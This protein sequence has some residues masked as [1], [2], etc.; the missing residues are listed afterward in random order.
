M[1]IVH[2]AH[3][4]EY[5]WVGQGRKRQYQPVPCGGCTLVVIKDDNGMLKVGMAA[6]RKDEHYVRRQGIDVAAE[7][8]K[9]SSS[10]ISYPKV[11]KREAESLVNAIP[12]HL[13]LEM[14][15]QSEAN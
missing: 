9:A 4:R 13:I 15:N 10:R 6:C 3:I 14:L 5:D 2:V 11:L 12:A 1:E 7:R 8:A